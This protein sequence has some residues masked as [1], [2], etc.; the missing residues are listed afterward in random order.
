[1]LNFPLALAKPVLME[2]AAAAMGRKLFDE[3]GVAVDTQWRGRRSGDPIILGRIRNPRRGRP[4]ITF[5][6][7][8]YFDPTNL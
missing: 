4:D 1:M 7:G 5:F 2:R 3:I 6:V 8:W